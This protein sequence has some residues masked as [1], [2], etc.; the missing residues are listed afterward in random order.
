[1]AP[2]RPRTLSARIRLVHF[3]ALSV[4]LLTHHRFA[5]DTRALVRGASEIWSCVAE[6]RSG[7][8]L[9]ARDFPPFQYVVAVPLKALGLP[10]GALYHLFALGSVAAFLAAW[11]WLIRRQRDLDEPR[12]WA[13]EL[14]LLS[15]P[16]LWY[17]S[18]TF[19]EMVAAALALFFAHALAEGPHRRASGRAR[20]VG[21]SFLCAITKEV[22]APFLGLM[23]IGFG[24]DRRAIFSVLLGT[25]SGVALNAGFNVFRYGTW[26]NVVNLD[27]ALRVPDVV[28]RER[29]VES[30]WLAPNGGIVWFWPSLAL[31]LAVL[32][33]ALIVAPVGRRRLQAI[34]LVGCLYALT[35]GL[36]SWYAP[37]G[38]EAWGPRLVLPWLP[39]FAWLALTLV[40]RAG[41]SKML[42]LGRVPL[43]ALVLVALASSA[44]QISAAIVPGQAEK[45]FTP[46][47]ACPVP[48]DIRT[49]TSEY[50]RCHEHAAWKREPVLL[51]ALR[52]GGRFP[53]VLMV[54]LHLG[55]VS[56]VAAGLTR[57]I[58]RIHAPRRA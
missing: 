51:D 43:I 47:A 27:P 32:L 4:F 19:N 55:A 42:A 56:C 50:Y 35:R 41:W 28:I 24:R 20:L 13:M 53:G 52:S 37:F 11:V 40:P 2:E 58:A 39:A 46:D 48:N 22:A 31:V 30:L 17:A 10:D 45:L 33:P 34:V 6:G 21:L 3:A 15:G 7:S 18:S 5:W 38:W 12:A 44:V 16:L 49:R 8:C 29:F 14:L 25:A 57:S 9:A 36:S 54:L 23:A 26:R 1:M